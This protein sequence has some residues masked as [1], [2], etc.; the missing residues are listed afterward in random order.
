LDSRRPRQLNQFQHGKD[1]W[2]SQRAGRS[3]HA[4]TRCGRRAS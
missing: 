4:Q 1:G 2:P 3:A